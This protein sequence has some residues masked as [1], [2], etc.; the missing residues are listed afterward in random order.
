MSLDYEATPNHILK[1]SKSVVAISNYRFS[2]NIEDIAS[3]YDCIVRFNAGANPITIKQYNKFYNNR[4]DIASING[5]PNGFFGPL[6]GFNNIPILFSRPKYEKINDSKIKE[7]NHFLVKEH[8]VKKINHNNID[9]IP[10][11]TY[12]EFVANYNYNN[13]STGLLTAYYIK[14]YLN[15]NLNCINF[16]IDEKM[17]NCIL[18]K[19]TTAHNT[20]KEKEIFNSLNIRNIELE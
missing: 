11:K 1:N 13:P 3:K 2:K 20:I 10:Y 19:S 18:N 4:T 5:W 6:D 14:K 9:F 16:F 12:S 15:T 7:P 17:F 8:F